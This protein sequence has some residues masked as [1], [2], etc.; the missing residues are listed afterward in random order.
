MSK[1]T[2]NHTITNIGLGIAKA[3]M[4]RN[5]ITGFLQTVY[6]EY[7]GKQWQQRREKWEEKLEK[8]FQA[9]KDDI[10]FTKIYAIPNFAQILASAAQG[11]MCDLEEDK[12]EL[13]VN[14][15]INAIK[16]EKIENTKM[17]IFLNMLRN[18]TI[19]HIKI[20][21]FFNSIE[22]KSG[23]SSAYTLGIRED[24]RKWH[25]IVHQCNPELFKDKTLYDIVYSDLVNQKM[26][27][28]SYVTYATNF[29][30]YPAK[31]TT[32]LADEFLEFITKQEQSL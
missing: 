7:A 2:E 17:H 22:E 8:E 14:T 18:F 27:K 10:D 21:R 11:A 3:V 31:Q 9:I 5:L 23:K 19:F 12:V 20:L 13:Y 32:V 6:D 25:E 16:K 15:V 1:I 4:Q 24:D 29:K 28:N 26:L 30:T